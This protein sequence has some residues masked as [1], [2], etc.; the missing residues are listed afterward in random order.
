MCKID[1]PNF[2]DLLSVWKYSCQ[3][4]NS[5]ILEYPKVVEIVVD[6]NIQK[7]NNVIK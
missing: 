1:N 2:D 5:S 6:S 7:S 4:M 3:M